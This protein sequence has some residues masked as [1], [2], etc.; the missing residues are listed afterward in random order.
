MKIKEEFVWFVW[1]EA[2]WQ[3]MVLPCIKYIQIDPYIFYHKEIVFVVYVNDFLRFHKSPKHANHFKAELLFKFTLTEEGELGLTAMEQLDNKFIFN[4]PFLIDF[5][6]K[7][8]DLEKANTRLRDVKMWMVH[9]ERLIGI[10][11]I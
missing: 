4:Q 5:I 8:A 6:I 11:A 9:N 10:I 1:F 3:N 2:S 7:S